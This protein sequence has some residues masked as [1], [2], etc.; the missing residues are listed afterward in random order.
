MR[1]GRTDLGLS[2]IYF[3]FPPPSRA[4]SSMDAFSYCPYSMATGWKVQRGGI[5]REP[6]GNSGFL[7]LPIRELGWFLL[8]GYHTGVGE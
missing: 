3:F 1:Q 8:L 4:G 6:C 7:G 2:N 5:V